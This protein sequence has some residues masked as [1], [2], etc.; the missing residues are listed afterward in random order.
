MSDIISWAFKE[1]SSSL[2]RISQ[3][4]AELAALGTATPR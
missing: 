3:F 1:N 2:D 4:E